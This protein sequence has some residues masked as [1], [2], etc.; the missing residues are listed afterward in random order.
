MKYTLVVDSVAAMPE[1]II[2]TRPIKVLPVLVNINGKVQPDNISEKELVEIY[3]GN[4]LSVKS[5]IESSPPTPEQISKFILEKVAPFCDY[6]ICQSLSRVTSPVFDNVESVA[7]QIARD[8]RVTRDK[9]GI[10]HPFRM[11]YLNTGTTIAGQGLV[12]LYADMLLSRGTEIQ[13]YTATIEKFTKV[14]RTYVIVRDLLYTRQR[15]IE[16]GVKTIG[17]GAALLGKTVGLTPIVEICN[18]VTTPISTKRGFDSALERLIDYT[19]DRIKDGLYIPIVNI[20]YAGD[21]NDIKNLD[22]IAKLQDVANQ[23]KVK[24]MFGVMGLGSSTVYGPGG[25]SI[26]IAPKNQKS[27]PD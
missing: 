16:K 1:K 12:A 25:F 17:F 23:H 21:L 2:K 26:G 24:L 15:A 9:L 20:S 10:E 27:K 7:S 11:T 4:A 6:A 22:V 19:I 8:A 5:E 13:E 14:V 18:D 3:S